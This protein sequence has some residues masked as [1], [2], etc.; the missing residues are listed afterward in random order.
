MYF[1]KTNA[2]CKNC[3]KFEPD[4]NAPDRGRCQNIDI[5]NA[6]EPRDCRWYEEKDTPQNETGGEKN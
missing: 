3:R 4:S 1:R 5:S 2:K 6:D